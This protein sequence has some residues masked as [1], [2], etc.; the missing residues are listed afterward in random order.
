MRVEEFRVIA[1]KIKRFKIRLEQEDIRGQQRDLILKLYM[2]ELT[3]RININKIERV[4]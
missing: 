1:N 4:A 3:S 2:T